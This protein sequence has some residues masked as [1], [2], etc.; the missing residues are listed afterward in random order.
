MF[1]GAKNKSGKQNVEE[2]MRSFAPADLNNKE[3]YPE[4]SPADVT[5]VIIVIPLI[6]GI[7]Q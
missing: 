2:K 4:P 6:H 5:K 1:Q 3:K 7:L